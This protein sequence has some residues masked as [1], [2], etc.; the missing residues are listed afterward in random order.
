M[1]SKLLEDA[2]ICLSL[3]TRLPVPMPQIPVGENGEAKESQ[4]RIGKAYRA[5]PLVGVVTGLAGALAYMVGMMMAGNPVHVAAILAVGAQ[6]LISGGSQELG[7]AKVVSLRPHPSSD[8]NG[9]DDGM[10]LVAGAIGVMIIIILKM[11]LISELGSPWI[12]AMGLIASAALG[13]AAQVQLM[14]FT[15]DKEDSYAQPSKIDATTSMLVGL[16][17]GALAIMVMT[18]ALSPDFMQTIAAFLTTSFGAVVSM[19]IAAAL[20]FSLTKCRHHLEDVN[21]KEALGWVVEIGALFGIV[22]FLPPIGV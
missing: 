22:A 21:V 15:A 14:T 1:P 16:T 3:L 17:I 19:G 4:S 9:R 10:G 20:F 2:K 18:G 7:F 5:A 8:T 6:I 13:R 12:A 11:F